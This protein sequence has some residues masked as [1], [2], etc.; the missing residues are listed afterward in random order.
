MKIT[1]L[2]LSLL[3][4]AGSIGAFFTLSAGT[5]AND[6]KPPT[7]G[8]IRSAR[9]GPWSAGSTWEG[10]KVPCTGA[11]VQVVEG[12]RVV[13]DVNSAEAIRLLHVAGTLSFAQDRDTRLDVGLLKVQQGNECSEDGFDCDAHL[14]AS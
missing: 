5:G 8:L 14:P 11:R 6:A 12:H 4:C 2:T 13:Y 10:G 1:R 7:A 9:S 3:G